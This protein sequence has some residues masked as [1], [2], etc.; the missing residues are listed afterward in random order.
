MTTMKDDPRPGHRKLWHDLVER[1]IRA[2]TASGKPFTIEKMLD[3]VGIL[4]WAPSRG[5][6]FIYANK[7]LNPDQKSNP[8]EPTKE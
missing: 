5:Q 4:S 1:G 7:M 6:A 8:D 2:A 3:S